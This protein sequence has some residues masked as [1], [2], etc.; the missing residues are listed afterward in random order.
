MNKACAV[1]LY[2]VAGVKYAIVSRRY[3]TDRLGSNLTG[4]RRP[5]KPLPSPVRALEVTSSQP[6][7][8][9]TTD[10]GPRAIRLI[11]VV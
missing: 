1:E 4:E 5:A 2:Q 6:H 10:N 11:K 3:D 9:D 8:Q 7:Q